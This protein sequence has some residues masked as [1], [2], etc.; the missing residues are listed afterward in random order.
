MKQRRVRRLPAPP[1]L[2]C[3]D[4]SMLQHEHAPAR[5]HL[6]VLSGAAAH[7]AE[8]STP[9]PLQPPLHPEGPSSSCSSPGLCNPQH[10]GT[11]AQMQ[12]WMHT[13][14]SAAPRSHQKQLCQR[15]HRPQTLGM[16]KDA[17]SP[18]STLLKSPLGAVPPSQRSWCCLEHP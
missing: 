1:R 3:R 4:S 2:V 10:L 7:A 6:S 12:T 16:Q 17:A 5:P 8:L 15:S 11:H 18:R 13:G 14:S 9:Q